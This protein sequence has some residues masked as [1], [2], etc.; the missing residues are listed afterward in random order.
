MITGTIRLM[1][2]TYM[3]V[4]CKS[5]SLLTYLHCYFL[6]DFCFSH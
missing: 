6:I 3:A 1:I 4:E 2:G 5:K